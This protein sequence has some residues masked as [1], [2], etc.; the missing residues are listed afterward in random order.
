MGWPLFHAS[1]SSF[2]TSRISSFPL[3]AMAMP[4]FNIETQAQ[5]TASYQCMKG[6]L[7]LSYLPSL[8]LF[9]GFYKNIWQLPG[10]S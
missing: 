5:H 3:K 9:L 6:L 2:S 1:L 8:I 7:F 4:L 10:I